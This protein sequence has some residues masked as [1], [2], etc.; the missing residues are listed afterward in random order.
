[1]SVKARP[2][3]G[4]LAWGSATFAILNSGLLPGD[5]G[6]ALCGPRG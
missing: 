6:E 4:W 2:V 1:M 3:T 5:F